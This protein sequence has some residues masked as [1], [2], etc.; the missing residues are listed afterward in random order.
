MS[1]RFLSH[2]GHSGLPVLT[3]FLHPLLPSSLCRRHS[4]QLFSAFFWVVVGFCAGV[5]LL[6]KQAINY[7]RQGQCMCCTSRPRPRTR[8]AWLWKNSPGK[9]STGAEGQE[10]GLGKWKWCSRWG[11]GPGSVGMSQQVRF[12]QTTPRRTWS[13]VWLP[14]ALPQ[15]CFSLRVFIIKL[16]CYSR[17]EYWNT[18]GISE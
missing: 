8:Q 7:I 17:V 15:H 13:P 1:R 14:W 5:H 9:T 6:R 11:S 18:N 4:R 3:S 12:W 10:P 2:S 16:Q